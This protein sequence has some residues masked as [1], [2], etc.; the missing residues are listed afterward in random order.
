[1]NGK[2]DNS[3]GTLRISRE[4]LAT[5]ARSAAL[6]VEGVSSI[7][8]VPVDIKE[9]FVKGQIPKTVSVAIKDDLAEIEVQIIIKNGY[10]IGSVSESVQRSVKESVQSM[11]GITVSKV[12]VVIAGIDF[13]KA[14]E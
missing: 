10:R 7:A 4:V 6:E 14:A 11:T 1:M 9:R 8:E 13:A 3:T 5:I 12:N 2:I